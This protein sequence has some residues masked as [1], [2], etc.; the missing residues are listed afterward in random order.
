MESEVIAECKC[1]LDAKV[2]IGCGINEYHQR[3][4]G[5]V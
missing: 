5:K 2:L 1:G 3:L 4:L